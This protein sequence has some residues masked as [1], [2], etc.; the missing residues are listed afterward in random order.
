MSS[1][2]LLDIAKH[3]EAKIEA[4]NTDSRLKLQPEFSALIAR[5]LSEGEAVPV[6]MRRLE[7]SLSDE[8]V[9]ARFDNMPV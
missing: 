6:R 3:L 9:E 1:K 5:M 2:S 4:A 7:A 8:A